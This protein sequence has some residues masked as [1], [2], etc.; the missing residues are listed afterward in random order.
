M[1]FA[2]DGAP[3]FYYTLNFN[4]FGA[5]LIVLFHQMVVNNWYVTVNQYTVIMGEHNQWWVRLYFV[6]FW[7]TIVL[8]ELNI[9]I[10]IVLEIFSAVAEKV[11]EHVDKVRAQKGLF[12]HFKGDDEETIREKVADARRYHLE[13]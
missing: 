7:V 3:P 9:L 6:S 1:K 13:Q 4:D 2:Q 8:I 10:A 11:M 5:A 12:K